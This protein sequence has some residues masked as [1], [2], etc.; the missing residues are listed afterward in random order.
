[1][2]EE[3]TPDEIRQKLRTAIDLVLRRDRHLLEKD[4]N[5][6]S[7]T[8]RLA[9]YL[10]AEFPGWN[11]DCEYN[12]IKGDPKRLHLAEE[13]L[14]PTD[15]RATADTKGRTVFPDIIVHH[16]GEDENLLVIEIKK[17]NSNVPNEFDLCKLREY[18]REDTL[19]YKYGVFLKVRT[20]MG[21]PGF[22]DP[23]FID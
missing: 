6:R 22:E 5:E 11:V 4:A 18:K 2:A 12:R 10:E 17:A 9:I 20:G 15:E 1:M 21:N 19:G 14:P 8:H 23:R 13:H 7:I 16:R 3:F